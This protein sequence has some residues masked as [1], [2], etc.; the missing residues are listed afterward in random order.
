MFP[1]D[2]DLI[3]HREDL[4]LEPHSERNRE[5]QPI[6]NTSGKQLAHSAVK[7]PYVSRGQLRLLLCLCTSVSTCLL[8]QRCVTTDSSFG[9]L[10]EAPGLRKELQRFALFQGE[11]KELF[12]HHSF[13]PDGLTL[14][15][16]GFV[17]TSL[18][19]DHSVFCV[20]LMR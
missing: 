5:G 1:S 17:A 8:F 16:G 2:K 3:T 7:A 19:T 10:R 18:K 9:Y 4:E 6:R 13:S 20:L 15:A 11:K 12:F 14:S